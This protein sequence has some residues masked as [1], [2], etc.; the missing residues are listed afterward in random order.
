M[1]TNMR[2]I[3]YTEQVDWL[4]CSMFTRHKKT[5]QTRWRRCAPSN[6][7]LTRMGDILYD[8]ASQTGSTRLAAD[9]RYFTL[10]TLI[11]IW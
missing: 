5:E 2:E 6:A 7:S 10:G 1:D 3:T 8:T 11:S 4:A 9:A